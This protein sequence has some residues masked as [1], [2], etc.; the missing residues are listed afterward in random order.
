[1]TF[2]TP[3]DEKRIA[4]A[5]IAA[6]RRTSGEIVA[7]IASES[8]S[9]SF[10]P[11]LWAALAA[12]V[13]PLPLIVLTWWPIQWIYVLQLAVFAAGVAVLW[14]RTIRLALVPAAIKRERA[15]A[16]AVEQFLVQNLHT[17]DGRTGVLVFV[18][19]AERYA[20]VLADSGIHKKVAQGTWDAIVA[21]LTDEIGHGNTGDA[22]VH[23]IEAIGVHLAKH[24]PPGSHDPNQLP[25]HLIVLA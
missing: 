22:F 20:E 2:V 17:T 23:A 15:H 18:S 8:D 3:G 1:M 25:K 16:R 21:K 11:F 12:L 13:V 24:V 4:A 5:L 10:V 9:Y 19:V 7:V 14:S 6:E